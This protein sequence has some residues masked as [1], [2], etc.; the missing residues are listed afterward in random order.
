[1]RR[2]NYRFERAERDRVKQTRKEEKLK[3]QLG[4]VPQRD[5][6]ASEPTAAP[7][8]PEPLGTN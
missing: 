7:E 1:M 5:D 8:P 3:R 2:P 4:R 6:S